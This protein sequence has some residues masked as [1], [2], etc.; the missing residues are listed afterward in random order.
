MTDNQINHRPRIAVDIGGTFTDFIYLCPQEGKLKSYKRLSTPSD[1]ALAVMEG[2]E[3]IFERISSSSTHGCDIIHGSTVA[4]NTLLE[5]K[6]V[7]TALVTTAGF[8]DLL[9]IGRQNRVSLYDLDAEAPEPLV[10]DELRFELEERM[11]S[12]GDPII[13]LESSSLTRLIASVQSKKVQSLA[14]C[15]L[16]SYTNPT[17]EQATRIALQDKLDLFITLSSDILPEFREFERAS[18]TTVNAYVSPIMSGYLGRLQGVLKG[19]NLSIMQSNGGTMSVERARQ[20]AVHCILSGPAGGVTGAAY[21]KRTHTPLQGDLKGLITLDMGGTST[22]VALLKGQPHLT[23]EANIGG[24]PIAIPMLDI[25]TI[26]AGGGSI[27]RF[28][29]GGALRVGPDSAG[30]DPGPACYGHG[31]KPTVTD[32]NLILG[33]LLPINYLGGSMPIYPD[34][35]SEAI[36]RL[37]AATPL[38]THQIA[39]GMIQ[40]A[41]AHMA[42]AIRVIS[43]ERGHDPRDY[44]LLSYGGAGGLHAVDLAR[45][46]GIPFVIIPAH[47]AVFSAFGMYVSDVIKDY[48]KTIMLPGDVPLHVLDDF[49]KPIVQTAI[50][51]LTDEGIPLQSQQIDRSID[52]R[53]AGQSYEINVPYTKNYKTIFSNTH[54]QMFGYQRPELECEIVTIRV[55]ATGLQ[56]PIKLAPDEFHGVNASEAILDTK[57]VSLQ[58]SISS[59]SS[60]NEIPVYDGSQLYCGNQFQGPAIIIR[61]DTTILIPRQETVEVDAYGSLMIHL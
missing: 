19:S 9:Q 54:D 6:G 7:R 13:E 50:Q 3:V 28:D 4:T 26:G 21:L 59:G 14:V 61:P 18:T 60:D 46:L 35:A 30:A 39:H 40:I 5:R 41:N 20:N 24:I 15:L 2:M 37:G 16:F 38:T 29:A 57:R 52:M 22:D 58:E 49:F 11:D 32:A 36:N 10:P 33:R 8:R 25:H 23:R 44:A 1:P 51:D 31:V 27:A 17:H 45:T 53:Y 56:T 47:A 42:R 43:V 55:K 48:S 34:R 12:A